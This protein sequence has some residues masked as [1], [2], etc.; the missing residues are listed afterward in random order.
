MIGK[1]RKHT[2]NLMVPLLIGKRLMKI[3]GIVKLLMIVPGSLILMMCK[4]PAA[5]EERPPNI[6]LVMA[7][8]IGIE[9]LG[10]Y[11]GTSYETPNLDRMAREGMLFTHAYA[12]PLCTPTRVQ[13][14]TGKYNHRNWLCFG[15]LDPREKTIGHLMSQAGYRTCIAGKWQLYSYDPLDYPGAGKRRGKGMH[16][17]D[18]GFEEYS[19]FHSLHTEDKG[20]RY[21][22]PTFLRNGKLYNEVEGAYGEDLSVDFIG[23]FLAKHRDEP[24]FIYYPMVLPHGPVVPTPISDA[25]SDPERRLEQDLRYFP[26]MVKYMDRLVGR[27]VE[28]VQELG[29]A[30]QTLILF[31]ADNGTDKRITSYMGDLPV[32]GGKGMT[33]QTGIRV[34]LITYWPGTI[35][36]GSSDDLIDASDFL[37][38]LAELGKVEIPGDWHTDG[39]SFAPQLK[40]E[41]GTARN[42]AFFWYDP[43][44]GWDKDPFSRHIFAL[45]HDFKYFSDGRI[46]EISGLIPVETELDTTRLSPAATAAKEKFSRVIEHMMDPPLSAAALDDPDQ[47]IK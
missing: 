14:M 42:Y 13:L 37:P 38:T 20:S 24:V 19:L 18:A 32:K 36:P 2:W 11:G 7:D 40:G 47:T 23:E 3:T 27:L 28:R 25:W 8:D 6:I 10:C 17:G 39:I 30:K 5:R 35:Q 4:G 16:P 22:N 34:P 31:Y 46:F 1:V 29:L 44:P 9:A 45:D 26:D 33:T 21:A 15:V 12:Q 41:E 43:R